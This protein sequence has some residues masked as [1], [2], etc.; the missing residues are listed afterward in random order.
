VQGLR[1][2]FFLP[3]LLLLLELTR[4]A[5]SR[6][7]EPRI[8]P[9]RP[10]APLRAPYPDG[11]DGDERV[12]LEVDIDSSGHVTHANVVSGSE[13]F[14]SQAV[15]SAAAWMFEPARRGGEPVAARIR[16]QIAFAKPALDQPAAAPPPAPS[17]AI[18][19]LVVARPD[20]AQAGDRAARQPGDAPEEVSVVGNKREPS[21]TRLSITEAREIPG[22]FGDPARAML[23]LPGIVP[24]SGA[25]PYAFVRGAPPSNT[26]YLV[27]GIRVPLLFHAGAGPSVIQPQL[28]DRIDFFPSAVPARF[29]GFAGG[30]MA[31]ETRAPQGEFHGEAAA[32]AYEAAALLEAPFDDGRAS[33]LAAARVGYPQLVLAIASPQ[34]HLQYWDYQQ[35]ATLQLG[36]RDR[37]GVFTFGSHDYLAHD[38]NQTGQVIEDFTS[39][40]HRIDVRYDHDF[41]DASRVRAA[42][43][44]GWSSQ[45]A[46]PI[47]VDDW[48]YAGRVEGETRLGSTVRL[49]AGIQ[50]EVDLYRLSA[51]AQSIAASQVPASANPPP[52]NLTAGA[53]ADVVYRPTARLQVIPGVRFDVFQSA[54]EEP[55]GT[56]SATGTIPTFEPRIGARFTLSP[57]VVWL[58][59]I[60]LAHQLPQ[61]RVGTAPGTAISVPGFPA[62]R[63][64][65]QE[66]SQASEGI[67]LRL[68]ADVELTATAFGSVVHGMTD[69]ASD[70]GKKV[71]F[72]PSPSGPLT[73]TIS[74]DCQD[75]PVGGLS[76]G[77]ELALRRS[78]T[79]RLTGWL[80]YTLSR[81]TRDGHIQNG[82]TDTVVRVLSEY[83][84]THV[85][86]A[87]AAYDLGAHWRAG[88]RVLLY[89]GTPYTQEGPNGQPVPPY[90]GY[91]YPMFLRTDARLEKR[92]LFGERSL[93]LVFEVQNV[94]ASK[95][96]HSQSCVPPATPGGAPGPCQVRYDSAIVIPS[97]GLEASF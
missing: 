53:Y 96:A 22:G 32:K 3:I 30:I 28:L 34:T 31:A 14:A 27:D 82:G 8:E 61:L 21:E 65:L 39:D 33:A 73:P 36:E 2:T 40:F 75:Q 1:R 51:S 15:A 49:R 92:W 9:P 97:V 18:S 38:D 7:D 93:A 6:A 41:D 60:G 52:T 25:S 19:E 20:G 77:V 55:L 80:S 66:S 90:Q 11:A 84:R 94:T 47:Y 26:G 62:G 50:G 45:G 67:E 86:N 5:S 54:R 17:P 69:L 13:P 29:G 16:V 68:P 71:T 44:W 85:L 58:S 72:G 78:L 57:G 64:G 91:R 74:Y 83:D 43:T 70:C 76:Y 87:I 42:F 10:V 37:V 81:T 89:S 48:T 24:I 12:V 79:A 35:R 56:T 95:E 46:S 59:S 4:G 63:V 88:A 23:A